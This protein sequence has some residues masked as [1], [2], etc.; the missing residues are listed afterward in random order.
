[1][2][3][4]SGGGVSVG[5][6]APATDPVVGLQYDLECVDGSGT[7]VYQQLVVYDPATPVPVDAA[8]LA[9]QARKTLPLTFPGV[10]TSPPYDRD[11]LVNL[12]TWLWVAAGSWQPSTATASVPGLSATVTAQPDRVEWSMG[13]GAVE[14]C[15]GPGV[16]YDTSLPDESQATDCSYTFTRSSVNELGGLYRAR[17]TMWWRVSW[18]ASDGSGGSLPDVYRFTDFT[19]RVGELQALRERSSQ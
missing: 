4:T 17:A 14:V 6:G 10:Q 18:T 11:Q 7:V 15:D 19:L 9:R 16:A 8:T 12:P 2:S 1:L 5:K 3:G 13:D